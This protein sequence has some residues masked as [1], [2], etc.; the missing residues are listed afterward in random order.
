MRKLFSCVLMICAMATQAAPLSSKLT[1]GG[2]YVGKAPK[3]ASIY[4]GGKSVR[5]ADDGCFVI[6]FG[7]DAKLEQYYT[8]ILED[9][10][11]QTVTLELKPRKYVIQ[12]LKVDQKFVDPDPSELS[13]I[14]EESRR[15]M[16]AKKYDT[17][18]TD[19]FNGFDW[20]I[21]GPITGVYG[22]QRVY[23]GVEGRPH[24][25]VDVAAPEGDPVYAPA[26]GIVRLSDDLYFSGGTIM[27]DHGH[28]ITSAFLHLS[29]MRVK[30]GDVIKRGDH[31]GDVGATG[32]V[33]GPHLDW[34]YNWFDVRLDPQLLTSK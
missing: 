14:R 27:I 16:N 10:T 4:Y 1:P 30:D 9:G 32:R 3:G 26:D 33:T 21:Y 18:Q 34:R 17:A 31:I 20:P 29:K 24:Y 15:S 5:V 22:S 11:R 6:G 12:R 7:R 25:G 28:G 2:I 8:Q 19:L 23:N 13:R